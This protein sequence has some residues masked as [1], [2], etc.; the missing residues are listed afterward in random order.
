MWEDMLKE[1]LENG[2]IKEEKDIKS[3]MKEYINELFSEDTKIRA[4]LER[5]PEIKP[6]LRRKGYNTIYHQMSDEDKAK[7]QTLGKMS[8]D[9]LKKRQKGEESNK[10]V[11]D[12]LKAVDRLFKK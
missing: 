8:R 9:V 12:I 3:I 1:Y 2:E 5:D 6:W 7:V 10:E 4:D 11:D